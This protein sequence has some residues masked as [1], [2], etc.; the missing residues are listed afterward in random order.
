MKSCQI[1]CQTIFLLPIQAVGERGEREEQRRYH[2][3]TWDDQKHKILIVFIS[4]STNKNNSI[5]SR[6]LFKKK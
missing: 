6:I 3:V 2:F 5:N 1:T 4:S